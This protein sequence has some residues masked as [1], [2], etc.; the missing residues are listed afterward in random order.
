[1]RSFL[2]PVKLNQLLFGAT[3]P[4]LSLY[5]QDASGLE[6][7]N[8]RLQL[9]LLNSGEGLQQLYQHELPAI[10]EV[11]RQRPDT[12]HGFFLSQ[13]L[14]G[15]LELNHATDN[16]F[17][18]GE[19]F[20]LRP[21]LEELF[22]NPEYV[23]VVIEEESVAVFHG[24][25]RQIEL[26]DRHEFGYHRSAAPARLFTG[27]LLIT[28]SQFRGLKEAGTQIL[29][30]PR[31]TRVPVIAVGAAELLRPFVRSCPHPFGLRAI[32]TTALSGMTCPQL[33][34]EWPRFREQVLE[35]H[36]EQFRHRLRHLVRSGRLVS[37]LRP[38]VRAVMESRVSRL[39]L[40]EKRR[41]WGKLC[42]ETGACE[43]QGLHPVEQSED[44][45]ELLAERVIRDGGKIQFLPPHFF[46]HGSYA[47][48]ML[49][50]EHHAHSPLF[51]VAP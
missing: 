34:Q 15:H 16:H 23:L 31:L 29:Q 38:L 20:Q 25:T 44:I 5:V 41:A 46:P 49:R 42:L 24:D 10:R 33:V 12:P 37:E 4:C 21:V 13:G 51:R 27:P 7:I 2:K 47:M 8:H 30:N 45:L 35:M 18:V 32:E 40:P 39:L 43:V 36:T 22:V 17:T 3:S 26:M 28:P 19:S 6:A 50:G 48:G 9:K 11:M 14:R 1:M